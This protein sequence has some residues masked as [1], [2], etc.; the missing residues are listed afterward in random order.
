MGDAAFEEE[1]LE[2]C[3]IKSLDGDKLAV[4]RHDGEI[5]DI[6][7][8]RKFS[9]IHPCVGHFIL[10]DV[11]TM[12]L[13]HILN[14]RQTKLLMKSEHWPA[15]FAPEASEDEEA[16]PF[17]AGNPNQRKYAEAHSDDDDSDF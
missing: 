17:E 12:E 6:K 3:R 9:K 7:R 15:E 16:D 1:K 2:A 13:A 4:F 11:S 5:I 10:L 14:D 8:P